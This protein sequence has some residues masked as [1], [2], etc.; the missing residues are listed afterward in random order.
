MQLF[1]MFFR[2]QGF[3]GP[4]FSGS[5]SRVRVQVRVQGPGP[6]FRSSHKCLCRISSFYRSSYRRCSNKKVLL[7]ISQ[8]SQENTCVEVSL[9]VFRFA[10]LLIR[11]TNIYV[12]L[13]ILRNFKEHRFGE[14]LRTTASYFMNKNLNNSS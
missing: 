1:P 10:I 14:H 11:D 2:V 4:G 9:Q 13:R 7:K 3:Q 5:G 6:G 8:Y 12:F